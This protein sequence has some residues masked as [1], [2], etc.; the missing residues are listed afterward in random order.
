[1][2]GE[3]RRGKKER[4]KNKGK[5]DELHVKP[6]NEIEID[7]LILSFSSP[8]SPF[9]SSLHLSSHFVQQNMGLEAIMLPEIYIEDTMNLKE[10]VKMDK[11][12]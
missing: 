2:K 8:L 9:H 6:N 3:K 5:R 1:M 12:S 11:R 10:N 7:P 4:Q